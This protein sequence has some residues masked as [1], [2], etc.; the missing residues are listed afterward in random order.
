MGTGAEHE[1]IPTQAQRDQLSRRLFLRRAGLVGAGLVALPLLAACG[2]D[3]AAPATTVASS[4]PGGASAAPSSG[5][6]AAPS[7]RPATAGASTGASAAPAG[8][9]APAATA[10]P[11]PTPTVIA[12]IPRAK[13]AA[14]VTGKYQ[15]IQNQDFHPDHNAF[16]RAEIQEFCKTQGWNLDISYASGFTQSGDLLTTLV[17]AVQAGNAP[18]AFF[19]DIGVRLYQSQNV[20]ESV[21]DIVKESVD[22]YGATY[23]GYEGSTLFD[24]QWW[25]LPFYGR[26]GGEYVRTD[27]FKK[28][29]LD[30][31]TDCTTYDKMRETALKI[32]DPD[33]KMWGWGLTV[34]RSG[35]G[36][37][38][39]QQPLLRFGSQLQD[40]DGQIVTFNSPETI[41]GL[42]WI[43]ETYTDPKWAKM[44]PPGVN[45]WTDTSNNEA[46]LAGTLA[47]TDNAGTMYAKAV[48]D[49]VPFADQIM[50]IPRPNRNSDNKN[51]DSLAG[52]R[53]HIIKGSKNKEASYDL[54]RHLISEPVQNQLLV[55][56]PGYV[57][58]PY[59]NAWKSD[60][61]QKYPNA[62]NS[63]ALAYPAEYFTGV[64]SPGPLTG[65]VD[66]ITAG[67]YY[68]DMAAEVLQGKPIEDVVK[69]YTNRFVQIYKDFGFKGS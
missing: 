59:K 51:L 68:T 60:L 20:L 38:N 49:K 30:P 23:P 16:L 57:L 5:A 11:A 27:I 48:F 7:A 61:V 17:G 33:N 13:S 15:F 52:A 1:R 6:S 50:F 39:V 40:K 36:T 54:F 4:A 26:A 19:H 8:S 37:T 66:T 34:N 18:D 24:G 55:T 22:K 44:L 67:N 53:L 41:A 3:L 45:S 31:T 14:K 65:A 58:P 21:S 28:Y 64:R 56:S 47:I 10:T 9:A 42:K 46:F 29:G 12:G 43:K 2:G 35:D 63:E 32:S 25:G 62:K 69:D